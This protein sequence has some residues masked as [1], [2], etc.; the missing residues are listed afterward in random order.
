[1]E[2]VV[3]VYTTFPGL[4]EAEETGR[5][6]VEARLAAC[7]NILPGMVS[8]Y[9]WEGAIERGE[10]VVMLIKTRASRAEE[11]RAAVK[12]RHSYT[13]PAILVLPIESVDQAY[14]GWLLA[15]T[16]AD[17]AAD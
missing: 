2:R 6:L 13:T 7:V 1:M 4:V 5:A 15:E 16:K 11:V 9:R 12:A 8:L 17:D 10:E 14:L 3:F